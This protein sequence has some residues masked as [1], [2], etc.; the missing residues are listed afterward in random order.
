MKKFNKKNNRN[1]KKEDASFN[2][3][4]DLKKIVEDKF[5]NKEKIKNTKK[6]NGIDFKKIN[7]N[8]KTFIGVLKKIIRDYVK[9]FSFLTWIFINVIKYLAI[10]FLVLTGKRKIKFFKEYKNLFKN[11]TK[12]EKR[13]NKT[14]FGK[15]KNKIIPEKIKYNILTWPRE[16]LK[17]IHRIL[18]KEKINKRE[19]DKKDSIEK[20]FKYDKKRKIK[21]ILSFF[22][23]IIIL[24]IP[25]YVLN[26]CNLLDFK[27]IESKV[28]NNSQT[29]IRNLKIASEKTQQLEL[30]SASN[31]FSQANQEF[32]SAQEEIAKID[33]FVLLA[34]SLS[35]NPKLKLA[36]VSDKIIHIGV[37][38]SD[39]G[40][41][42]GLALD[43]LFKATEV[44]SVAE[45][46]VDIL[47]SF[48]LYGK[49]ALNNSIELEITMNNI[50]DNVL[51]DEYKNDFNKIKEANIVLAKNLEEA[52]DLAENLRPFLG[53]DKDKRYLLIF[54]NNTELRASGGFMGS[55]ALMD[56][57][58]GNI[59]NLEIPKG[60]SYDTEAGLMDKIIA[61]EPLWLVNPLWH[62]W[63]AN[64]WPDWKKSAENIAWFYEKSAGPSVDGVVSFTPTVLEDML[65]VLGPIDMSEE[66]GII[67][68]SENFWELVQPIVE[69]KTMVIKKEGENVTEKIQNTQPKK[70][71]GDLMLKIID[72]IPKRLDSKKIFDLMAVLN[73]NLSQ[74]QI[75]LYFTDKDLQDEIEKYSWAGRIKEASFDYLSIINTNIA[76]QKTD[77]KI[78]QK[79]VHNSEIKKDGS[80]I[81]DLTIYRYHTGE[82]WTEFTGVRNVNWLRVYV[83]LGSEL[84]SIEGFDIPDKEYFS[85]PEADWLKIDRLKE[86]RSAVVDQESGTKIYEDSGKTVFANW[87]MVDPGQTAI[88][89]IKYKLPF[90]FLDTPQSSDFYDRIRNIFSRT[91]N[92]FYPYSLVVQKQPGDLNTKFETNLKI[93]LPEVIN[94]WHYPYSANINNTSWEIFANLD[95]D[96]YFCS[97]WSKVI[98]K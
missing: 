4:V 14:K 50:P 32:S 11:K 86:E 47:D 30:K 95:S 84:I 70:I 96:K 19:V 51:P 98:K 41:N 25:F 72:E 15:R 74:K 20:Y 18:K 17:N 78:T 37:L 66:Y 26:Y 55:F 60:G 33:K 58:R 48:I 8:L 80:I 9:I 31:Y 56:M 16:E 22:I 12:F 93:D 38:G 63:D 1:N 85:Y 5:L 36:S 79:I 62:F 24:I 57:R 13:K 92:V 52:I 91:K 49:K 27:T 2:F 45:D 29:A 42:L 7:S 71:I 6:N 75:L 54:Q 88:I 97:L 94:L 35:K 10:F 23:V 64:W 87:T 3:V 34:A 68:D 53:V 61:P 82:K 83:P 59:R 40:S 44:N 90:N 65:E 76:G 89:K 81:N 43:S 39:L 73:N 67:I 77:K 28:T 21:I 69:E 46:F